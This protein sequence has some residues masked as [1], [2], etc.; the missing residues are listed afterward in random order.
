[1]MLTPHLIPRYITFCCI[2]KAKCCL[3]EHHAEIFWGGLRR[4][5][6]GMGYD[7][8][9][10]EDPPMAREASSSLGIAAVLSLI[11]GQKY[12]CCLNTNDRTILNFAALYSVKAQTKNNRRRSP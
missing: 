11:E 10:R 2:V 1:M 4:E 6:V 12:C 7:L 8:Q 3:Q 9:A 5:K